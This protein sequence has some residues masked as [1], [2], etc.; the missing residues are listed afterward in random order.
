V[1]FSCSLW[2]AGSAT[3]A[4]ILLHLELLLPPLENGQA[5]KSANKKTGKR[6]KVDSDWSESK[7][8]ILESKKRKLKVG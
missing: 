5:T 3:P 7:G 1:D 4:D 8:E 2:K 6:F